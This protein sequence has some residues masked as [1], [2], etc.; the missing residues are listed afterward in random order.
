[1]QCRYTD[2]FSVSKLLGLSKVL[3]RSLDYFSK[4]RSEVQPVFSLHHVAYDGGTSNSD[5]MFVTVFADPNKASHLCL[6][7]PCVIHIS[8][9]LLDSNNEAWQQFSTQH[10]LYSAKESCVS[11]LWVAIIKFLAFS[12]INREFWISFLMAYEKM[13]FYLQIFRKSWLVNF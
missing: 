8:N 5:F 13:K 4:L 7:D 11:I 2:R 1:M 9:F 12:E 10:L 3:C 6:I